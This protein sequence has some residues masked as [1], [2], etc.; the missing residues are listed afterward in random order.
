MLFASTS[1]KSILDQI[2]QHIFVILTFSIANRPSRIPWNVQNNRL[3][4]FTTL[5]ARVENHLSWLNKMNSKVEGSIL[6]KTCF[7]IWTQNFFN[8][9][10]VI[11]LLYGQLSFSFPYSCL[12]KIVLCTSNTSVSSQNEL[13]KKIFHEEIQFC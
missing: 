9:N 12:Y 11:I 2:K 5:C 6:Q 3:L 13:W 10:K 1:H 4:I 8:L 7:L